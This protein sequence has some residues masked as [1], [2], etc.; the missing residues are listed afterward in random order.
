MSDTHFVVI[1]DRCEMICGEQVRF[2]QYR[3]CGQGRMGILYG[4]KY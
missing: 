4:P 1:Y 3:V 2:Q